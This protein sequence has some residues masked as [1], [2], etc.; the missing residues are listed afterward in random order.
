MG[1]K[2]TDI[3]KQILK[4]LNYIPGCMAYKHWGGP[5]GLKGVHDIICCYEGRFVSIEVKSPN[6]KKAEYSEWQQRFAD[7]VKDAQ[8]ISMCVQSPDEVIEKLGLKVK[9]FPLFAKSHL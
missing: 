8:G 6:L 7:R 1:L 2:E 9:L 5:M 3:T 4:M